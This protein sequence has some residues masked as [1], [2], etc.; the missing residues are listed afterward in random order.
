ML[1]VFVLLLVICAFPNPFPHFGIC[2]NWMAQN[3]HVPMSVL[4]SIKHW[5][6]EVCISDSQLFI[7]GHILDVE[8]VCAIVVFFSS[9]MEFKKNDKCEWGGCCRELLENMLV[10]MNFQNPSNFAN[11]VDHRN[12]GV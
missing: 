6:F 1:N 3:F 7:C 12:D 11:R 2:S 9:R 4:P 10:K 5:H 8:L